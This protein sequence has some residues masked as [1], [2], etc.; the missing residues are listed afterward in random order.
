MHLSQAF[1]TSLSVASGA[2]DL[3]SSDRTAFLSAGVACLRSLFQNSSWVPSLTRALDTFSKRL[4]SSSL[5]VPGPSLGGL[6]PAIAPAFTGLMTLVYAMGGCR[7]ALCLGS[8]VFL[9]TIMPSPLPV[10]GVTECEHG[11]I[12]RFMSQNGHGK[13][14]VCV[15]AGVDGKP[16]RFVTKTVMLSRMVP[17]T[18][19]PFQPD[20]QV[21]LPPDFLRLIRHALAPTGHGCARGFVGTTPE[22]ETSILFSHFRSRVLM[23][24]S[25]LL[26]AESSVSS[27]LNV[28]FVA[29]I[30][31][32]S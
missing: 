4:L 31:V 26:Q 30:Y 13:A 2:S 24:L 10:P 9:P 3:L 1:L 20:P 5:C 6:P 12:I 28:G 8:T 19:V 17:A 7:P 32:V 22:M 21:T 15:S 11:T 18:D 25:T 27:F 23:S 16:A 14:V 29:S